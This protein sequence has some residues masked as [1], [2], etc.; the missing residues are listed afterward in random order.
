MERDQTLT[1]SHAATT[2]LRHLDIRSVVLSRLPH[3]VGDGRHNDIIRCFNP[4]PSRHM[5]L[6]GLVGDFILPDP[7]WCPDTKTGTLCTDRAE[8]M[9]VSLARLQC[10]EANTNCVADFDC[11]ELIFD[12]CICGF[13][14]TMI[15]AIV[16]IASLRWRSMRLAAALEIKRQ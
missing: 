1:I 14:I 8:H 10:S 9:T 5:S 13:F 12:R 11:S 7:I 3:G 15:L 6:E 4:S 16:V 2:V